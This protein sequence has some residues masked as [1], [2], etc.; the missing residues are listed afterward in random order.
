M[1]PAAAIDRLVLRHDGRHF[2]GIRFPKRDQLRVIDQLDIQILLAAVFPLQQ[3]AI[4]DQLHDRLVALVEIGGGVGFELLDH[5]FDFL[6]RDVVR[7]VL[8]GEEGAQVGLDEHLCGCPVFSAEGALE[9]TSFGADTF[10]L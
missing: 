4:R 10:L 5:R 3:K 6:R 8:L 7:G 9:S 1:F 2:A